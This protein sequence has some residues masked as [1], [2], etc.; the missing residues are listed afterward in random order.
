M[1]TS[2]PAAPTR[3]TARLHNPDQDALIARG[4]Y[5]EFYDPN[6]VR[7][8]FPTYPF[9]G[10]PAGYATR[11][12]LRTQGLRPGGQPVAA[13]ILWRHRNQHRVAY[14]YLLADAK[15]KRQPTEGN[16]R[17]VFAMLVARRTCPTCG[18]EKNYYIP[19]RYGECLSCAGVTQ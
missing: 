6:G 19:R 11:R 14:L 1:T 7:Y 16:W 9:N 18:V 13:Q 4:M 2:T 15:P 8:G 10:A 5:I 17:A 12:Q 3:R